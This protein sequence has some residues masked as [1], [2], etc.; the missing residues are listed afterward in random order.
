MSSPLQLLQHTAASLLRQGKTP[1]LALF[2]ARL[3]SQ[4]NGPELFAAYQ[5][6]RQLPSAEQAV[7]G[8]YIDSALPAAEPMPSAQQAQLDR[9]EAKLDQLLHLLQQNQEQPD[10]SG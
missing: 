5:Q 8:P 6:W 9:I 2:K 3:A 7:A 10:V 1:S 4:L